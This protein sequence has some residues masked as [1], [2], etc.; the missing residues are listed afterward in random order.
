MPPIV[1]FLEDSTDLK[2]DTQAADKPSLQIATS[3]PSL[4]LF[5][6][7]LL[8]SGTLLFIGALSEL[9]EFGVAMEKQPRTS[10]QRT[11]SM[12][13]VR[14]ILGRML[15]IGLPFYA[16]GKLGGER[17][18]TVFLTSL[19]SD[20]MSTRPKSE[21]LK[22]PGAFSR[23]IQHQKWTIASLL[24]Q[25]LLDILGFGQAL[26]PWQSMLGY[27][28]LS[29]S[30]FVLPPPYPTTRP[31][32]SVVTSPLPK[33][34]QKNQL[35]S[36][37]TD[38]AG[39]IGSGFNVP[40]AKSPL[41]ST[42]WDTDLT[43][44]SGILTGFIGVVILLASPLE[45]RRINASNVIGGSLAIVTAT[46]SFLFAAPRLLRSSSR[47]GALLGLCFTTL[48]SETLFHYTLEDFVIQSIVVIIAWF[49][50][51]SDSAK[52]R[53]RSVSASLANSSH[54][55]THS[56]PHEPHSKVTGLLLMVFRDWPLLHSILVEKDSRRIFYFMM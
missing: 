49:A 8:T 46:I 16:A 4:S 19:T 30:V 53:P 23:T 26:N 40:D 13:T 9:K 22:R 55:R 10:S 44:A 43:L 37:P 17:V 27:I 20:L 38:G 1:Q 21:E 33:K 15:S 52:A 54:T 45:A 34:M 50:T 18:A 25:I 6:V 48:L 39:D 47:A 28:A 3:A 5:S 12:S 35:L 24:L 14:R 56:N 32:A 11:M 2:D 51:N 36:S 41:V 29:T 42:P 7:C 31:R